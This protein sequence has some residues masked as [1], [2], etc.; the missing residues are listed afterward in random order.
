MIF[1]VF[2][3]VFDLYG[4]VGILYELDKIFFNVFLSVIVVYVL[5]KYV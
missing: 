2:I 4:K 3:M 1:N 5:D